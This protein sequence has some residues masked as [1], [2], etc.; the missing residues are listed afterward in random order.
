[1]SG[2][3]SIEWT[4]THNL[5]GQRWAQFPSVQKSEADIL[6][7]HGNLSASLPQNA[8]HKEPVVSIVSPYASGRSVNNGSC[9]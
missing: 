3:T 4:A 5:D 7:S 6:V 8:V 1:M 9:L 2:Q